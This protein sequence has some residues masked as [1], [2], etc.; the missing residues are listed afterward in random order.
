MANA[1]LVVWYVFAHNHVPRPED[2]PV[3]P[4]A[5]LGFWLKP[6]GFF[7][8]NPAMDVPPTT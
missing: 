7:D 4:V 3:M 2:W 5:S 1:P 6:D 8:Q